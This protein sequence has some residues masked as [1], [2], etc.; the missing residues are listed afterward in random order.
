MIDD[1]PF[2]LF[3]HA[4]AMGS[5]RYHAR[6]QVSTMSA[7]DRRPKSEKKVDPEE[8]VAVVVVMVVRDPG[9]NIEALIT[10][11]H[12]GCS[13]SFA[14]TSDLRHFRFNPVTRIERP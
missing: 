5:E 1:Q 2:D 14:A 7:S 8:R 10:A 9:R 4:V 12:R 3:E 13:I 6:F 11:I